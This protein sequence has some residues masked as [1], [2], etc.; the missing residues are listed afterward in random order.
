MCMLVFGERGRRGRKEGKRGCLVVVDGVTERRKVHILPCRDL[1]YTNYMKN[2]Q[3]HV[4]NKGKGT[5]MVFFRSMRSSQRFESGIFLSLGKVPLLRTTIVSAGK[6]PTTATR[7]FM[8]GGSLAPVKKLNVY[9]L[10]MR[11]V[12]IM[13][14]IDSDS[15]LCQFFVVFR[16]CGGVLSSR[17]FFCSARGCHRLA[18]R[19]ALDGGWG[20]ELKVQDP[21]LFL[22]VVLFTEWDKVVALKAPRNRVATENT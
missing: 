10:L 13:C 21:N 20:F 3:T 15:S 11:Q 4:T 22:V 7:F 18:K 2:L 17:F 9:L 6:K 8:F 19:M 12:G 5:F 14:V 16:K 1:D